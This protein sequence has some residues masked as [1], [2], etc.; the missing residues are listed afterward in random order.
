MIRKD[1]HITK[2]IFRKEKDGTI[3]AIFPEEISNP[4]KGYLTYYAHIGQHGECDY[5]YILSKTKLAKPEEYKDLFKE[6]E[7]MGYNLKIVKKKLC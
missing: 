1:Q 6:L 4:T 7:S 2:V 3:I 5:H